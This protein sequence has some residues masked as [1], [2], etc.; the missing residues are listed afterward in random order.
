MSCQPS[1]IQKCSIRHHF[2]LIQ[3]CSPLVVKTALKSGEKRKR[4]RMGTEVTPDHKA[5]KL[6]RKPNTPRVRTL[7]DVFNTMAAK[8]KPDSP[9][10]TPVKG[11]PLQGEEEKSVIVAKKASVTSGLKEGKSFYLSTLGT[12][13]IFES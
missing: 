4:A 11:T 1:P 10:C 12:I 7:K 2:Y 6:K 3:V 8:K 9:L 5:Q 13:L